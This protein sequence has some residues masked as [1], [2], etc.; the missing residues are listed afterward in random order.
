MIV[1]FPYDNVAPLELSDET[2]VDFFNLPRRAVKTSSAVVAGTRFQETMVVREAA[3]V[4]APDAEAAAN[5]TETIVGAALQNPIGT[6]TLRELSRGK[7]RVLVVADDNSRPTPVARFVNRVLDEL[8]AGGISEEQ[9]TIMMA[10]GTHRPMTHDEIVAKLGRDVVERYTCLNHDWDNP[11]AL[12]YIGDTDQGVPVWINRRVTE[13]D[14]VIGIGAIMPIDIC[15]YTGGGK[16]LVPGLSGPETVNKMHWSR[17]YLPTKDVVGHADNPIRDSIDALARKAGLDFIVNV[18]LDS[19]GQ[20]VD[21]VAGDMTAAHREGCG[22]AAS[23]CTVHFDREYDIVV[24]DS[25]PFDIEFWQANKALDAAGHFVR[26]GGVIILVTPCDEGWSQTHRDDILKFGYPPTARI[27]ELVDGGEITHS[28][29]GVHMHQVSE[30]V[31]EKSRLILVTTGLPRNEVEQV[32]FG[33]AAAPQEAYAQAL[34]LVGAGPAIDAPRI[35]V[36]TN[37]ARMIPSRTHNEG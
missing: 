32:G 24:A 27:K 13:S 10:L 6:P 8:A 14:L 31:V 30:V 35:A 3:I 16:I 22:R 20:V 28:V 12:E 37:A 36:L 15:G 2:S 17:V 21:C 23:F 11:D 25:Y 5:R 18:I 19:D 29:V 9:I 33:W 7:N 26:E 34:R 1:R 4:H